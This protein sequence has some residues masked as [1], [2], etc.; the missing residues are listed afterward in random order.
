MTLVRPA[1]GN[2]IALETQNGAIWLT[3][4]L[5][6]ALFNGRS[7]LVTQEFDGLQ[8]QMLDGGGVTDP[9][10]TSPA[11]ATNVIDCRGGGLTEDLIEQGANLAQEHYGVVTD[12]F[13]AP[14]AFSDLAK[15]FY[16]RERVNLPAP[17]DGKV[18]MAISSIVTSVGTIATKPDIFL[19]MGRSNGVKTP[20]TSATSAKAPSAITGITAAAS[21][22]AALSKFVAAD[23]GNWRYSFT[24]CN[25]YGESAPTLLTGNT[26]TVAAGDKVT[27]TV[28]ITDGTYPATYI[29]VYRSPVGGAVGTAIYCSSF[30]RT[31]GGTTTIVDRN[32]WI[33]GCSSAY[34]IQNNLQF[35]SLRQL[36]PLMKIPLA[37]VAASIRW[38]MLLYCVPV[39][40]APLKSTCYI[41]IRD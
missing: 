22:D 10:G 27:F 16:P 9:W 40:Y 36:A 34:M 20:P 32:F 11:T 14:R 4:R 33:Q 8:K 28:S 6:R 24:A 1:H 19:R 35:H 31:A 26:V 7:D 12:L 29:R 5:E 3:E 23:A 37:T 30:P 38:M 2:V 41:N 39:V 15:E 21:A 13:A 17:Q 25:Q 18:G